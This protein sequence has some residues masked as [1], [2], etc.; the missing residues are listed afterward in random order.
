MLVSDAAQEYEELYVPHLIGLC[1]I[2]D[3]IDDCHHGFS[4]DCTYH[5]F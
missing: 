1:L 4:V 3:C 5:H 2:S